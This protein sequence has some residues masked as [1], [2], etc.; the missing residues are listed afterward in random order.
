MG[1]ESTDNETSINQSRISGSV[2]DGPV[3]GAAISITSS[4][5]TEL[6]QLDSDS[7]ANFTVDIEAV[8]SDYPV[9][10]EA[11]GGTDLVTNQSPDFILR[12]VVIRQTDRAIANANP[13][14]TIA[15]ATASAMNGG[16]DANNLANAE[17]IVVAEFNSGLT[18][19]GSS[20]PL[21]TAINPG[22]ISEMVRAAETLSEIIRRTRDQSTRAGFGRNGDE[23]IDALSADLTDAVVDG[24][25][26]AIAD[27]R[28]AAISTIAGAQVLLESIRNELRVNGVDATDAMR[29]AA[30]QV[31][32]S[33]PNPTIDDLTATSDVLAKIRIGLAA[34]YEITQDTAVADLH[35]EVFGLQPGMD[36]FLIRS[37][38]SGDYSARLD[39]AITTIANADAATIEI[40]NAIARSRDDSID[41]GVN[42]PPVISGTPPTSVQTGQAYSFTP[43]ASDPDGD[44]LT[45]SVGNLPSWATFNASTGNLGGTP[46]ANDIGSHDNIVISVSDGQDTASLPAFSINVSAVNEP[47]TISGSAPTTAASG[48]LYS[49]TPT[50]SDPNGD[51]LT[52][53]IQNRPSWASFDTSTG[54]LSGTPSNNVGGSYSNILISVSDGEFSD[55]LSAFTITVTVSNA[56]PSIGGNPPGEVTIGQNYTFT[57]TASDADGDPLTFSI[58]NLPSWANFDAATG[59]ISGTPQAG[60]EGVYSN[61]SITVSDGIDTDSLGPFSITVNAAAL[62]SVTLNWTPPTENEDGSPL[63]DLAGYRIYWGPSVDN[64]PNSV[65]INNPSISSYVIDNLSPGTY[66]FAAKAFNSAGVESTFSNTATKTI[67]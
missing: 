8:S 61:I 65:T 10:I 38:V 24:R 12:G 29:Q 44:A 53:S 39:N 50:A 18:T 60:D 31:S 42:R 36:A 16:L 19:L 5:G 35:T 43:Q 3:V 1:D 22:N 58:S 48:V 63:T 52:F 20:G 15:Y 17:Q 6:G 28:I 55:S 7:D 13:F 45:Y 33:T 2:G 57:P 9:T 40:V 51:T 67:P 49:F 46:G 34:A 56:A 23:V 26:G 62:G 27:A 21:G 54:Q 37:L 14:S 32:A 64:Y 4:S 59:S 47:P 41:I 11:T 25:G 30:I 66:V